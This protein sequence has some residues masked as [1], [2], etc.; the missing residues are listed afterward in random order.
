MSAKRRG[1]RRRIRRIATR[2]CQRNER[3]SSGLKRSEGSRRRPPASKAEAAV[4]DG[5]ADDE[6][7]VGHNDAAA[8]LADESRGGTPLVAEGRPGILLTCSAPNF[9][10]KSNQVAEK[11]DGTK[12]KAIISFF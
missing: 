4:G 3:V 7:G 8:G 11:K 2:R 6:S 1:G 12:D 5:T 10:Q 9:P